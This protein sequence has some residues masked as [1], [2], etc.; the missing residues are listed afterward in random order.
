MHP[1]RSV[2]NFCS[3]AVPW[4][5]DGVGLAEVDGLVGLADGLQ[6]V[7]GVVVDVVEHARALGLGEPV[8][9][10][11]DVLDDGLLAGLAGARPEPDHGD[12]RDG[13]GGQG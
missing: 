10:L 8:E 4:V 1:F 12:D 3:A 9:A 13:D 2:T 7:L 5:V 11:D 6:L